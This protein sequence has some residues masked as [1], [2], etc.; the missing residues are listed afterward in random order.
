MKIDKIEVWACDLPLPQPIN[1]GRF[2]VH[3]RS[4]LVVRMRAGDLVADCVTQSRG[5]PLDVIVAD[6]LAPRLIGRDIFEHRAIWTDIERELTAVETEGA[7]RRAWSALDICLHDLRAK[8]A[9]LPLWRHLGG[10]C[11]EPV[12]VLI[13][14]GYALPDEV[15]EAF[16][17]RLA[18]RVAE[19]FSMI[20]LEAGHYAEPRDLIGRLEKLREKVGQSADIV[21]DF[22]WS[23]KQSKPHLAM[24]DAIRHLGIA[25]IEDPF[26][27]SAA[28]NYI[29]LR[30]QTD[31]AI[32]CGDECSSAADL[33]RLVETEAVD[34]LRVDATAIG[35]VT[36]L[37]QLATAARRKKIRVSHHEHPETHE[38]CVFGFGIADHVEMFPTDRPFDQVHR[39]IEQSPFDRV[40]QGRLHPP[41][42]PGTGVRLRLGEVERLARRHHSITQ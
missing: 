24:L 25:W 31:L 26:P 13:V 38:H 19:G 23:W 14:E 1:L 27:S 30:R 40:R 28:S 15:G 2:L 41:T 21:L 42:E 22:A 8:A 11:P 17:D 5:S 3:R 20:K 34:L 35:G 36:A 33:F 6:L 29:A 7:V 39:I 10:G 4:H 16:V 37:E 9:G 18:A 32:G 12:P